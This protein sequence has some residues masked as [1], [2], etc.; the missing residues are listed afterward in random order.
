MLMELNFDSLCHILY[1]GDRQSNKQ[2]KSGK[3]LWL[4]GIM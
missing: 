4:T 2:I 3:N 1:T